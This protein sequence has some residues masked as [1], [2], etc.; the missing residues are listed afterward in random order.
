MVTPLQSR[1]IEAQLAPA[2]TAQQIST[3]VAKK[4]LDAAKAE[5]AGV[6]ALLE[7]AAKVSGG[8]EL[9]ARAT[10]KGALLDVVA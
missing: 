1:L 7:S 10:G 4:S 6:I 2:R 3:A 9:V 8:D 5:G